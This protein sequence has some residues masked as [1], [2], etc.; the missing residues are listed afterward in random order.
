[1]KETTEIKKDYK[2]TFYNLFAIGV[3]LNLI[4]Y[5]IVPLDSMSNF[6]LFLLQ[7]VIVF[8]WCKT[9]NDAWKDMGKKNGWVIGL[10]VLIPFGIIICLIIAE[11]YLSRTGY[12]KGG[13]SFRLSK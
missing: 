1:M 6:I 3:F 7:F 2:N 5:I 10:I 13:S 9:F 8:F 12:W 4:P 11:R